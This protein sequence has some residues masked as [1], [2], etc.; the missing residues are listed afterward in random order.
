MVARGHLSELA[1]DSCAQDL[2]RSK[3]LT[4]AHPMTRPLRPA[5]ESEIIFWGADGCKC[6][7]LVRSVLSSH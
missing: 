1:S 7:K 6:S 2:W 3:L 5:R 4:S